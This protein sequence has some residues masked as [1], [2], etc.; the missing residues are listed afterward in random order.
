MAKS[1]LLEPP[2]L[3]DKLRT[4]YRRQCGDWLQGGV[5]WPLQLPLGVPSEAEALA[6]IDAVRRWVTAWQDWLG[7]GDIEW[8]ERRWSRL[9]TQRLPTAI[10]FADPEAVTIALDAHEAWNRARQRL[11]TVRDRWPQLVATAARNWQLLAEWEEADFACLIGLLEWLQAHPHSGLYPRQ[12]PVPG[13]DGKWLERHR[14]ILLE[15]LGVLRETQSVDRDLYRLAGLR[16]LPAR[17]RLRLLDPELRKPLGGLGDIEAPL[18]DV[19]ALSL[20]V[21]RIVIVENLQTGLAFTDLP[22]TVVFMQQGY[23]VE[24]FGAIPWLAGRPVFYW[25]DIDTHGLAIL[26]RLRR[27]IPHVRSLLMEE[28]TLLA[29]RPLWGHEAKLAGPRELPYLDADEA[30]LYRHLREGRWGPGVRLEQERIPWP[31][32]WRRVQCV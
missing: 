4:R 13:V 29:H 20:P 27:H 7:P 32:A 6:D 1:F 28:H 12:L 17:L 26:D 23:A 3:L 24:V 9:G 30:A 31:Y 25:G 2:A 8:Q 22:G 19:A 15:W 16:P 11:A 18:A 5:T 14:R 21:R 10:R